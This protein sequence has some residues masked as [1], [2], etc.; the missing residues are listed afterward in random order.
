MYVRGG[1]CPSGGADTI[2]VVRYG[3][4]PIPAKFIGSVDETTVSSMSNRVYPGHL[5]SPTAD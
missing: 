1:I 2:P 5:A 3:Q 4:S